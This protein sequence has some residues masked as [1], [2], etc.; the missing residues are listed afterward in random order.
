MT[1]PLP[2]S[3]PAASVLAETTATMECPPW[4]T[5]VSKLTAAY[6][7]CL[8]GKIYPAVDGEHLWYVEGSKG[9]SYIVDLDGCSCPNAQHSQKTKYG[10]YHSVAVQLYIRWQRN[11][12]PMVR[13]PMGSVLPAH[14]FP[15][16]ELL[17]APA[18]QSYDDPLSYEKAPSLSFKDAP[19][20]TLYTGRITK[21]ATLVQSRDFETGEPATWPDGNPKM[22]VV[23]Q[24]DVQGETRSLWAPKPSAMFAALVEAQRHA[25]GHPMQEGGTLHVKYTGTIPNVKNPKLNGAKQYVCKY[26]PPASDPF[27]DG[28]QPSQS[29]QPGNGAASSFAQPVRSGTPPTNAPRW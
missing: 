5:P 14:R 16:K 19:E 22:S 1:T 2:L 13:P 26:T 24:L 4:N 29:P 27:T 7:A 6:E 10:C 15:K 12:Q 17:M 21:R 23:I 25:G 9:N 11:L 3:D 8:A 20:G 28:Q 18:P